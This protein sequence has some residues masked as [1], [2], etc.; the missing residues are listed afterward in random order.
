MA[1]CRSDAERR[2]REEDVAERERLPDGARDVERKDATDCQG[3]L[4]RNEGER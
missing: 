3:G 2:L 1:A 4:D